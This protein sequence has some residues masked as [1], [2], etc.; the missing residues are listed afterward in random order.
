MEKMTDVELQIMDCIWSIGTDVSPSQVLTLLNE[1]FH[2]G[3]TLQTLSTYM[4]R[5]AGKG[6][7]TYQRKGRIS[8][9]HPLIAKDDYFERT[10]V[11]YS[12]IWGKGFLKRMTA[13]LIKENEL[14]AE[15][16]QDLR[17]Y[18]DE[19]DLMYWAK[20][21]HK[22]ERTIFPVMEAWSTAIMRNP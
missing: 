15:E 17:D 6:Y 2:R 4:L 8:I 20:E 12:K 5:M 19:L 10:A 21:C 16:I 9:Y 14:S 7:L 22:S 3:W 11:E 1:R 18:L 13:A